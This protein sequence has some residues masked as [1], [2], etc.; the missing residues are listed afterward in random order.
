MLRPIGHKINSFRPM[1]FEDVQKIA[2]P[3]CINKEIIESD[4]KKN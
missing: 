4:F 3:R 2:F 1:F